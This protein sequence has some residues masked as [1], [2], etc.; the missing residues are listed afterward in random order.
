M[1][2][3]IYHFDY[4]SFQEEFADLLN[5]A[6]KDREVSG[7]KKFILKNLSLL[8][9]PWE[10]GEKLNSD[11]ENLL[12]SHDAHEYGDFGLTKYYDIQ[13]DGGL[14]SDY[15]AITDKI[16]YPDLLLGNSFGPEFNT[17]D[18]GKM[19]S[20][21]LTNQQLEKNLKR[22]ESENCFKEGLTE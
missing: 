2:H 20:Y 1:F 8:S 5:K 6:L 16:R 11:W 4:D 12:E 7:L 19:G 14:F 3:K 9:E 21:F 15:P 10:G 17:F 13:N 22:L 18:P